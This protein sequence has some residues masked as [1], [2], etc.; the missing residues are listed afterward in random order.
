VIRAA[1]S[2]HGIARQALPTGLGQRLV[3]A[4]LS[5][6]LVL[7]LGATSVQLY[8]AYQRDAAQ[9][10]GLVETLDRSFRTG[11]TKALWEYNFELVDALLDGVVNKT[12]VLYV[13]LATPSGRQW[14]RGAQ[15]EG[16]EPGRRLV[17]SHDTAN[18]APRQVGTL[19]VGL[20]LDS[21]RARAWAQFWVLMVTNFTQSA[22]ATIGML[23]L[24]GHAITRH[25]RRIAAHVSEH[26]WM[27][28]GA[29]LELARA[30]SDIDDEIDLIVKAI[31]GSR[32]RAA[33]DYQ[34]IADEVLRRGAAE[35]LATTRSAQLVRANRL[36]EQTNREQ[37]EFSYALAHDLKAPINSVA[38][39]L[40]EYD[41]DDAQ[42]GLEAQHLLALARQTNARMSLLVDDVL[43]YSCTIGTSPVPERIELAELVS[44]VLD[45]LRADIARS[46]AL[47]SVSELPVVFGSPY[48]VRTLVQNLISNAVKFASHKRTARI[49]VQSIDDEESGFVRLVVSD[50]GIGIDPKHQA[51]VF[52]LF[53]RLHGHDAYPGSGVGLAL[54]KRIVENHGGSIELDSAPDVGTTIT[55]SLRRA[56]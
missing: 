22:L 25:L 15:T 26:A 20:S 29:R 5:I 9:V 6:N 21:A 55:S 13:T 28:Q 16:L 7:S 49:Q 1:D 45:D 51:S 35:L 11:F 54:C 31:N 53:Q 50:N 8:L 27:Q 44:D 32:A 14:V 18:G 19:T 3:L 37:A 33:S 30:P 2:L 40:E 23:L 47:I 36:L 38:M 17:F 39:L 4:I 48:Q 41:Q 12:D 56:A 42:Q 10:F 24:F 43:A 46:G 34:R 52:G